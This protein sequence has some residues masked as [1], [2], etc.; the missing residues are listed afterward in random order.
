MKKIMLLLHIC[1]CSLLFAQKKLVPADKSAITGINLPA[2]S[3][4]D[5]RML[6]VL[7]AKML[8]SME[9]KK[10]NIAISTPEVLLLPAAANGGFNSDSLTKNLSELGWII[11]PVQEDNKYAWL[12]KENRNLIMYFSSGAKETGLYFAEAVS[13]PVQNPQV[14]NTVITQTNN[15]QQQQQLPAPPAQ[16]NEVQVQQSTPASNS[17]YTFTT[18]NFDDGW[19]STVQEDWVEVTKAN[20]KVLVHYPN[21]KA[22][23]YN[24]NLLDGLK[25][26]WDIL[27]APRYSS[28][29]NFEFRPLSGWQSIEFA[30]ADCAEKNSGN[31]V[32]VVFF[33]KNYSGGAGKYLEFI[34]PDKTSFEQEFGAYS[35]DAS[36]AG[37]DKMA[38]MANYNKFAVAAPDLNGKWTT[39]FSG[40]QQY[41]NAYTG[42]NAG[43]DTHA[44]S[45]KFEFGNGN[46]YK[47][48]IAVANG[49]VGNIKFQ[50]AKSAGKFSLPSAWQIFLPDMEGRAK[51][52]N[53]FFSCIKGARV[54]WVD[55]TGYAKSE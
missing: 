7:S 21:K 27:V 54:L 55:D 5:S 31:I 2:G 48:E 46:T 52:Y 4:Q 8:L 47:W 23:D 10:V 39:N 11:S 6:S 1:F 37:W 34:T 32:H 53:I 12:Q 24:P 30:E 26:A 25:T 49:F 9:S 17:A 19:T 20:I 22:D 35:N 28:A 40:I 15:D 42:A 36:A 3:K 16:T 45:Q 13:S 50:N 41:V 38:S 33:K 51:T 18:T 43:M 29:S 44:S 14:N